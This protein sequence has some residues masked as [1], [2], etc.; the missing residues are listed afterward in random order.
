MT[1][2]GSEFRFGLYSRDGSDKKSALPMYYGTF[3]IVV[4]SDSRESFASIEEWKDLIRKSNPLSSISLALIQ[5]S[6][7]DYAND[8]V[9]EAMM[10]E[11]SKE[12]DYEGFITLS[13][14]NMEHE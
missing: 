12:T 6:D 9:T 10:I 13:N 8:Q 1:I 3:I 7:S 5:K 14:K 4:S 11:K 2:E